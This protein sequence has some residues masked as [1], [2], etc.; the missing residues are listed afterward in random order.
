M[1][2]WKWGIVRKASEISQ[3]SDL[4]WLKV[5]DIEVHFWDPISGRYHISHVMCN[6]NSALA[7]LNEQLEIEHIIFYLCVNEEIAERW[8]FVSYVVL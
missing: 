7:N 6:S 1:T 5:T 2:V 3:G 4:F 8:T